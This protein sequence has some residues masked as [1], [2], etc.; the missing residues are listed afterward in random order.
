MDEQSTQ[1]T[2]AHPQIV[3]SRI[4]GRRS[5]SD[6]IRRGLVFAEIAS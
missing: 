3:L 5:Y 1:E 4:Q 2:I 6:L